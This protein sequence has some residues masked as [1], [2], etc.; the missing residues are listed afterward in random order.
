M[1]NTLEQYNRQTLTGNNKKEQKRW[2]ELVDNQLSE[3]EK[4]K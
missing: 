4:I 1:Q 2:Q 3:Y